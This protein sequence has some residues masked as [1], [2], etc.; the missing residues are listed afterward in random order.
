MCQGIPAILLECAKSEVLFAIFQSSQAIDPS[1]SFALP[2]VRANLLDY[3]VSGVEHHTYYS[4]IGQPAPG[5]CRKISMIN[6]SNSGSNMQ[7]IKKTKM[8]E[9]AKQRIKC[10]R[11]T[12]L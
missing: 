10:H 2:M 12:F 3:R 5:N 1:A 8:L 11:K 6:N 4:C 7:R 9:N